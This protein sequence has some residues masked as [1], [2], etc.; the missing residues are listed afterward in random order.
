MRPLIG[1]A[2]GL[3]ANTALAVEDYSHC[4]QQS[5]NALCKAYLAGFQQGLASARTQQEEVS[6]NFVARALEQRAGERYRHPLTSE[7]EPDAK[8]E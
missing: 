5:D 2:F 6:G 7:K 8:T 3:M 1:L 4:Q